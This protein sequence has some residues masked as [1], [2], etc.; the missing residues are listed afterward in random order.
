MGIRGPGSSAGGDGCTR[1]QFFRTIGAGTLATGIAGCSSVTNYEFDAKPVILPDETLDQLTLEEPLQTPVTAAHTQEVGG[2]EIEA[3]IESHVTVYESTPGAGNIWD[4]IGAVS[5]PQASLMGRTLN[6]LARTSVA[7][8]LTS[9]GGTRFLRHLGLDDIGDSRARV[10]WDRG[11]RFIAGR[12]GTCLGNET[13]LESYAGILTGDSPSVAFIHVTRV[14]GDS[15][16]IAAAVH[17]HE[18]EDP[19]KSLTDPVPGYLLQEAFETAVERFGDA[20][21]AFEYENG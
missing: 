1:R 13:T 11:P 19:N 12:E 17:G 2:V 16:V 4:A 20:S 6:P 5:T 14:D 7:N 3:S 21:A 15:I 9:H 10:Q 8:L 18:V